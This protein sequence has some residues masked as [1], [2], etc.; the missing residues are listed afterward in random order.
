[1]FRTSSVLATKIQKLN[2]GD[3]GAKINPKSSNLQEL[4][5]K[6][7]RIRREQKK[8]RELSKKTVGANQN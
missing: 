4:D 2:V 3:G 6:V 1:M 5:A 8:L 7:E